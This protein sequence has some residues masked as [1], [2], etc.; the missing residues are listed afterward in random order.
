M[1]AFQM[2]STVPELRHTPAPVG[3]TWDDT[4]APWRAATTAGAVCGPRG[5]GPPGRDVFDPPAAEP[6]QIE[7]P[8]PVS[9][10]VLTRCPVA[11]KMALQ[12]AGATGG[13]AGSPTPVGVKSL[14]MK[15]QST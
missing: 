12:I 10:R 1:P 9:G 6:P 8:S 14:W 4:D 5:G 7:K 15:W 13:N 3:C 2:D 11:A